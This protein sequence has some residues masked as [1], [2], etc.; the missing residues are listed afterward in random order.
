[1]TVDLDPTVEVDGSEAVRRRLTP[2]STSTYVAACDE[3]L[4]AQHR[5]TSNVEDGLN[6]VRRRQGQRLESTIRSKSTM[7]SARIG[8][9]SVRICDE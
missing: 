4:T 5:I 9:S 2:A 7:T 3:R 8:A 6:V 1:V